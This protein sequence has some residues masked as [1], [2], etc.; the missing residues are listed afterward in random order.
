MRQNKVQKQ[1]DFVSRNQKAKSSVVAQFVRIARKERLDYGDF[2]YVCQ[3]VRRK[4]R[5]LRPHKQRKLPE[6]MPEAE[7]RKFFKVIQEVGN[8]QHEIMLKLLFF[9]AL[10]VSELV[11][12]RVGDIDFE[13]CKIFVDQG[14]GQKDR[15]ILFPESFRLVLKSSRAAQSISI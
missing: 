13:E 15:Y 9:T 1:D 6:L 3:Q 11:K 8:L 2:V 10:R 4:L 12:I 5:L 14:K 7:L